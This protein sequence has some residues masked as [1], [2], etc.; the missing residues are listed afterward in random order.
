MMLLTAIYA[1]AN[2]IADVSYALL[3]PRIRYRGSAA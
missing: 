2:L 1:V 3:N